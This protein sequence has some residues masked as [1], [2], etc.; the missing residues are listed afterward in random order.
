MNVGNQSWIIARATGSLSSFN[1]M[2]KGRAKPALSV[3]R[4]GFLAVSCG[5]CSVRGQA[6]E[7]LVGKKWNKKAL[8]GAFFFL[9]SKSFRMR[10]GVMKFAA[11]LPA[12]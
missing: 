2:K 4:P 7:S 8:F 5:K 10:N 1:E 6:V 3:R 9:R 12:S 11:H